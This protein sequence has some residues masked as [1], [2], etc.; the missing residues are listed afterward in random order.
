MKNEGSMWRGTV[1]GHENVLVNVVGTYGSEPF[2]PIVRV[3]S[4]PD[5]GRAYAIDW[6]TGT[7]IKQFDLK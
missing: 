1:N 6:K 2:F 4:G 7:V 3:E 5:R